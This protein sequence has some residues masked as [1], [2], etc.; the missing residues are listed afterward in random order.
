MSSFKMK[1]LSASLIMAGVAVGAQAQTSAAAKSD[2]Q[3]HT[4]AVQATYEN[5]GSSPV[6]KADMHQDINPKA[7]PMSKTEF[8]RAKEI[9]FQRCAGCHGV[10]RKGANQRR[11]QV[12]RPEP[13][14][15]RP[16]HL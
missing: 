8:E 6:G 11:R 13:Y 16:G 7:P 5:A 9:Y 15:G 12:G 3:N 4:T 2:G 10:L 14:H 1:L